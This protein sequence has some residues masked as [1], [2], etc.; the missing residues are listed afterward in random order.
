MRLAKRPTD[1]S[2]DIGGLIPS[3]AAGTVISPIVAM[4]Y[5]QNAV[6]RGPEDDGGWVGDGA[7]WQVSVQET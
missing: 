3:A 2:H 7:I 5:I 4:R 1:R 6:S